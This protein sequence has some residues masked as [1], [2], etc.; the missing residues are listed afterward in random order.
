LRFRDEATERKNRCEIFLLEDFWEG[1]HGVG[2]SA[3]V[4]TVASGG[5]AKFSEQS[6]CCSSVL[7]W[8]QHPYETALFTFPLAPPEQTFLVL[9]IQAA[10]SC[11]VQHQQLI[12]R[13]CR[14]RV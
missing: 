14:G 6:L 9:A 2:S 3:F 7:V 11:A 5:L 8:K 10:A 12:T 13:H 1:S 4:G